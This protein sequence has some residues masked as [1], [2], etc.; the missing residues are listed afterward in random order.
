MDLLVVLRG[1]GA[2]LTV[3][4]LLAGAAWLV[5]RYGMMLP[6]MLLPA[7]GAGASRRLALVERLAIDGRSS[8]VLLRRDGVEHLLLLAATGASVIESGIV[9]PS[10]A[11]LS[12][13]S[14]ATPALVGRSSQQFALTA[15]DSRRSS[16]GDGL[17]LRVGL[18][19]GARLA[20]GLPRH[21][22]GVPFGESAAR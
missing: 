3:L 4:G 17:A 22:P 12:A 21:L 10:V 9:P 14:P 11:R 13:T 6:A 2:L 1:V 5:R 7:L 8:I 18:R 15:T 16:L 19:L 20:R